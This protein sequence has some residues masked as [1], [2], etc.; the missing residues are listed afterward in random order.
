MTFAEILDAIKTLS[1][2][3]QEMLVDIVRHRIAEKGRQQIV[4]DVE[5]AL[6]EFRAG[7][8]RTMTPEEI[9]KELSED[10]S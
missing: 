10:S 8:T 1:V 6:R 2:D 4:A 5:E 9:M 3:D 7:L